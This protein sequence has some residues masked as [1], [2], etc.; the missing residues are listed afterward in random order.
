MKAE[1]Y[2]APLG[3]SSHRLRE[4]GKRIERR[5]R[6]ALRLYYGEAAVA[7]EMENELIREHWPEYKAVG[8]IDIA[9]ADVGPG[10]PTISVPALEGLFVFPSAL[11]EVKMSMPDFASAQLL[12]LTG[13]ARSMDAECA[14]IV[15]SGISRRGIRNF[16]V[17]LVSY[18]FHADQWR[19]PWWTDKLG[20]L[21]WTNWALKVRR[22][23]ILAAQE[24]IT[25]G[26]YAGLTRYEAVSLHLGESS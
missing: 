21:Q 11:L 25:L 3:D 1:P 15:V 10:K 24:V 8:N 6:D 12:A 9:V 18:D 4:E 2:K 5:I 17:T 16:G 7:A 14:V 13:I 26:E 23:K 22:R 19:S 20:L